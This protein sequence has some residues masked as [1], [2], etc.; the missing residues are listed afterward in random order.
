MKFKSASFILAFTF[1]STIFAAS[2][3]KPGLWE[4]SFTIKSES[5]KVEK[6]IADLKKQMA[7]MPP[8]QRKMM[9]EM[10]AKNGLGLGAGG[11]NIVKVCISKE[12]AENLD[13]PN[14]QK[15][16]CKQEITERTSN[17][18]KMKFDCEGK[19]NGTAEFTLSDPGAY[20]GKAV[21]NN[22]RDGK[23]DRMDM[24]SKGKWLS[25]N[26]GNIKPITPKKS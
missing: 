18:M 25:S 8:E 14:N 11:A 24:T 15:D 20:T 4:H 16:N 7:N 6:G 10:M 13:F 5:G 23:T 9:E 1:S 3:M 22:I 17:S 12:Q 2:N 26:C 21:I 19:S